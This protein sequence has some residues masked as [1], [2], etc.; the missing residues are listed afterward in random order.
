MYLDVVLMNNKS[1][2]NYWQQIWQFFNKLP[3]L[4]LQ[5][6]FLFCSLVYYRNPVNIIINIPLTPCNKQVNVEYIHAL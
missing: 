2:E 6:F 5:F 4:I 3:A 1:V